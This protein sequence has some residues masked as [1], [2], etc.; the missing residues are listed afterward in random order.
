MEIGIYLF[1][2]ER[3]QIVRD[4]PPRRHDKIYWAHVCSLIP[5]GIIGAFVIKFRVDYI[6]PDGQCI[7]GIQRPI[8]II[9][10][11]YD[12]AINV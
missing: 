11:S 7:T 8:A 3:D 9:A 2:I 1:L 12:F 5:L 4:R 6:N 10:V